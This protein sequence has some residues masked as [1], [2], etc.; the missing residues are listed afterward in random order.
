[1]GTPARII[2]ETVPMGTDGMPEPKGTR[3]YPVTLTLVNHGHDFHTQ[4]WH[5]SLSAPGLTTRHIKLRVDNAVEAFR[6]VNQ[7]LVEAIR[8]GEAPWRAQ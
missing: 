8:L 2:A 3:A 4:D 5:L 1:M 6:A 7:G